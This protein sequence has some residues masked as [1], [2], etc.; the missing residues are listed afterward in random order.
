MCECVSVNM[1]IGLCFHTHTHTWQCGVCPVCVRW[2][3]WW[4]SDN[5]SEP[6]SIHPRVSLA[7]CARQSERMTHTH[8]HT[9]TE[10]VIPRERERFEGEWMQGSAFLIWEQLQAPAE[11]MVLFMQ[12]NMT[13]TFASFPVTSSQVDIWKSIIMPCAYTVLVITNDNILWC[14][15]LE[16]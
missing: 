8:T 5:P 3:D 15:L 9:L 7:H 14:S 1:T 10:P 12:L 13:Q 6:Q 2:Y 11:Q 4:R 16:K